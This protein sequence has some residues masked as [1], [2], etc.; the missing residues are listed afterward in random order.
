M[1][2][3]LWDKDTKKKKV[4]HMNDDKDKDPNKEKAKN[5]FK[6]QWN[7]FCIILFFIYLSDILCWVC[8]GGTFGEN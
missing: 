7:C 2:E 8:F 1:D 5:V 6:K 4:K 3:V